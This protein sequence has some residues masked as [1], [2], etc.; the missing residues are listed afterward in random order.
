MA[1]LNSTIDIP[2]PRTEEDP[3]VAS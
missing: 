1:Q 3:L 2:P